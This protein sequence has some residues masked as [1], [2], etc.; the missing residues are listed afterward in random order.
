MAPREDQDALWSKS[1]TEELQIKL[2]RGFS[3]HTPLSLRNSIDTPK[4]GVVLASLYTQRR[5]STC[6]EDSEKL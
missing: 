6:R 3:S 1:L 2:W 4:L 5:G